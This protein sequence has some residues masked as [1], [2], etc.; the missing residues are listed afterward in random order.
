MMFS[1][2]VQLFHLRRDPGL[3]LRQQSNASN[4]P[5]KPSVHIDTL[6]QFL[7]NDRKVLRFSAYWD[8]REAQFGDLRDLELYYFLADDTIQV[9]ELLPRNSGRD[10]PPKFLARRRIPKLYA[11]VPAMGQQT[12]FTVLNVL[13]DGLL[14][15][16]YVADSLNVGDRRVEYYTDRDLTIG[17]VL[18]V[19]GRPVHIVDCDEFTR[20]HYRTR[21]GIEDFTAVEKPVA[22]TAPECGVSKLTDRKLPAFNG[23][24]SHEDSEGNCLRT[25]PQAPRGD[26]PKFL[27]YDGIKLRFGAKMK[28]KCEDNLQRVF[29]IT[30]FLSTDELSVYELGVR[31]SGFSGGEFFKRQRFVLPNTE[32]LSAERPKQYLAHHLYIGAE[33]ELTGFVFCLVTADEFALSYMEANPARFVLSCVNTIMAKVRAAMRP[34][35][36]E[37]VAGYL[38]CLYEAETAG[39]QRVTVA[40]SETMR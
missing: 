1:I 40:S 4:F 11:G 10:A 18:N 16:R 20:Q 24:G 3:A 9:R 21:Y 6:G 38:P 22:A 39:G 29:V 33:L 5:K 35:Y 12:P 25:I 14:G 13:G 34:K 31:N 23:W 7:R 15:G 32:W 17:G 37:F 36:K 19:Y 2:A 26:F 28:S 8:D 30:Y 27:K